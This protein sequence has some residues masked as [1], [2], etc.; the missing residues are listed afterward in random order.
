M[1]TVD[2][3]EKP[4]I[5][6]DTQKTEEKPSI[7]PDTKRTDERPSFTKEVAEFVRKKIIEKKP[8]LVLVDTFLGAVIDK[9]RKIVRTGRTIA[10]AF[11]IATNVLAPSL[12]MPTITDLSRITP[13]NAVTISVN[14]NDFKSPARSAAHS[15]VKPGAQ[16]RQAAHTKC[17][18]RR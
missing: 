13:P 9:A 18:S 4:F 11:V 15:A 14:Q 7:N 8:S 5:N 1:T 17:A 6:P 16:V 10:A 3:E 12:Q 2:R